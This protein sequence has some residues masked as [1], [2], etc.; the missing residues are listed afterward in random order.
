[1]PLSNRRK[2]WLTRHLRKVFFFFLSFFWDRVSLCC[3]SPGWSAVAQSRL[4]VTS[5][6]QVQAILLL[7]LPSSWDYRHMPPCPANFCIY[8][9][10]RV[11]SY[12]IGCFRILD[13]VIHLPQ[14]PKVL[15]LQV[16]ATMQGL[17]FY[18][19]LSSY[20]CEFFKARKHLI[21]FSIL[22]FSSVADVQ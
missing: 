11:S 2:P 15:G 16:W 1:M 4:T 8:S 17:F 20:Y 12:W 18:F 14:P 7:S 13:L 3:Q 5:P 9:R 19:P 21:Y 22:K 10:D 6:S